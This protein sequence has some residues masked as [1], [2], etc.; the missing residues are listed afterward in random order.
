[1]RVS[2]LN[3]IY[4]IL[5]FV[6]LGLGFIGI[7]LPVLPT[8]PFLLLASFFFAKG[9]PKFNKWFISTK[10]YKN[11]LE[12]FKRTRSMTL[13][14][15]LLIVIPVSIMLITT[16]ILMNNMYLRLLILF[17]IMFIYYYFS[18]RIN[19]LSE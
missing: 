17:L 4:I 3:I 1:M 9:S 16:A 18:F 6:F 15:K 7:F 10:I 12:E 11:H 5:A 19:T 8:T 2:F 14:K 13:R